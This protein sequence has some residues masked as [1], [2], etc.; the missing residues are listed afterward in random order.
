MPAPTLSSLIGDQTQ[1]IWRWL[2][3]AQLSGTNPDGS[4]YT[5]SGAVRSG[6]SAVTSVASSASNVQLL[7]ANT[8]RVG[9]TFYNDSTQVLYLKLGVTA[10]TSSYTIQMAANGYYEVPYG[11]T[12]EIDGIWASANGNARI[13]ELS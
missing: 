3:M 1:D 4:A 7:A 12:G 13:T 11:Y 9:A 8:N 5:T 10:S 2:L 6:T